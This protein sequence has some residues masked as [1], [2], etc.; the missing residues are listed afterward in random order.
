MKFQYLRL[1]VCTLLV[2]LNLN[3]AH[4][5]PNLSGSYGITLPDY[6]GDEVW[7]VDQTNC[8]QL[9]INDVGSFV[10]DN[11]IHSLDPSDAPYDE[12]TGTCHYKASWTGNTLSVSICQLN[13]AQAGTCDPVENLSYSKDST[14]DLIEDLGLYEV[15]DGKKTVYPIHNVIPVYYPTPID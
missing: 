15:I 2:G 1:L 3:S 13:P 12:C 14:G 5:C 6:Q 10:I 8:T 4:A 7:N 11:A 9:S